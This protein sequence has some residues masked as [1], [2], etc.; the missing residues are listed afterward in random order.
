[1]EQRGLQLLLS[2]ALAASRRRG[3]PGSLLV[4]DVGLSLTSQGHVPGLLFSPRECRDRTAHLNA[5]ER[6][7]ADGSSPPPAWEGPRAAELGS[8]EQ[9]ASPSDVPGRCPL[10]AVPGRVRF[11][12]VAP[13]PRV[14]GKSVG[15]SG[16]TCSL[17]KCAYDPSFNVWRLF[18]ST[19]LFKASG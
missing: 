8:R 18:T 12:S 4:G 13:P 7:R 3:L 10:S 16:I 19:W 11:G 5:P 2:E 14:G 6:H 15:F 9:R 17:N 1:M